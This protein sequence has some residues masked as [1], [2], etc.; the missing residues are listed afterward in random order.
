M[1]RRKIFTL[2]ELLVV[3]AIIAILASMLLPALSKAKAAAT[4]IKCINNSKQLGLAWFMYGNDYDDVALG[5]GWDANETFWPDRMA[6]YLAAKWWNNG[7]GVDHASF[8]ATHGCPAR[9]VGD[10]GNQ[11]WIAPLRFLDESD[12]TWQPRVSKFSQF[13]R[14]SKQVLLA[15][16]TWY[17]YCWG[18]WLA[19]HGQ[20]ANYT[21]SDGHVSAMRSMLK[22][23][24]TP[25]PNPENG[26]DPG[27][28]DTDGYR[29]F[30][31]SEF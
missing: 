24:V 13:K 29:W 20:N 10:N 17:N 11:P 4:N 15:E 27:F 26:Y 2:I 19:P 8:F 25:A 12:D 1:K 14:P 5:P 9:S 30:D 6:N 31:Y 21:F 23:R 18:S 3:I 7:D 28:P 16:S 22:D